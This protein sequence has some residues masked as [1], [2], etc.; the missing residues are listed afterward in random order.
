MRAKPTPQ[1][2][3]WKNSW[4]SSTHSTA[5]TPSDYLDAVVQHAGI[6]H[7]EFAANA[8]ETQ[9]PRAENQAGDAR[10]HQR[11]GAHDARLQRA[12]ERGG[13]QAV[14]RQPGGS[15]AQRQ[16]LGVRRG[17]SAGDGGIR[18][19]S[20]DLAADHHY[21]SHRNLARR[22]AFARPP[23]AWRMKRSSAVSSI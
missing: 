23:K 22:R 6:G 9:V 7:L 19:L 14:I 5:S 11:A 13:F 16:D 10:G 2:R 21:R 17:V 1:R 3:D 20:G 8:A 18:S 12:I 15:L 4:S